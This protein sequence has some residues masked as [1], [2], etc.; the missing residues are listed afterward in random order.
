L[1]Q[2]QALEQRAKA[3]SSGMP[4]EIVL[5][6]EAGEVELLTP[7][8]LRYTGEVIDLTTA[9]DD[10]DITQ[11][12]PV[13]MERQFIQTTVGRVISIRTGRQFPAFVNGLLK[14]NGVQAARLLRLLALTGSRAPSFCSITWKSLASRTPQSPASPSHRPTW[15]SLGDKSK[16]VE[17][18]EREVVKVQ[19]QYLRRRYHPLRA[20]QNKIV[21]LWGDSPNE[22]P[23]K[24]FRRR[25]SKIGI[26]RANI[27]PVYV[28][29]D[30]GR[31]RGSK[32]QIPSFPACADIM[33]KPSASYG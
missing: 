22:W 2:G 17:A 12:F 1:T 6:L 14:K 13:R 16:L 33:A 23:T 32:Q 8:R 31:R 18:A 15:S 27:N 20:L 4:E 29:A 21:S 25:P 3:A 10:Q 9:Y 19:Q 11:R 30:S 24:C 26:K 5:A 7:I 28:M